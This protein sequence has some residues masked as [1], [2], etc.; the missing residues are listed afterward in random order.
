MTEINTAT[1]EGR[2]EFEQALASQAAALVEE[3]APSP[4]FV[5]GAAAMMAAASVRF[6]SIT[7][8]FQELSHIKNKKNC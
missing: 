1:P 6:P 8:V 7:S 4:E 5:K 3:D 2:L